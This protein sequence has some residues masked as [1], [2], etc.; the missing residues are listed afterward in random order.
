MIRFLVYSLVMQTGAAIT[1]PAANDKRMIECLSAAS[2]ASK[3]LFYVV[4]MASVLFIITIAIVTLS[5]GIG[6]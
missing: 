5:T 2:N 1:Q 6:G 4:G 3:M